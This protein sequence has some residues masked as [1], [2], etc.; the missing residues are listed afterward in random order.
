MPSRL[1]LAALALS[2][3]LAASSPLT[4]APPFT[5]GGEL[6]RWAVSG[7]TVITDTYI[8]L[9]PAEAGHEG[10]LWSK[11]SA[12]LPIQ[13]SLSA[14]LITLRWPVSPWGV[15]HVP[16]RCPPAFFLSWDTR[17][18]KRAIGRG[19]KSENVSTCRGGALH[20]VGDRASIQGACLP[21]PR[22]SLPP[23]DFVILFLPTP[24][25]TSGEYPHPRPDPSPRPSGVWSEVSWWRRICSLVHR[26]SQQVW[27]NLWKPGGL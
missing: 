1:L 11:G 7:S 24:P 3:S 8:R 27:G 15:A 10:S 2:G 17:S 16:F 19:R 22:L 9:T 12:P 21:S 20:G 13:R 18:W 5:H 25:A 4:L 26:R 23:P 6:E 14:P